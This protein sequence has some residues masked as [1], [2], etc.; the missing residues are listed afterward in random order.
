MPDLTA[1]ADHI[2]THLDV[3]CA[4]IGNRI[5]A[6][7]AERRAAEYCCEYLASLGLA[8]A[9]IEDFPF[10]LWGYDTCEVT[11]DTGGG[12]RGIEAIPIANSQ[13]TPE[14]GVE[15]ELIYVDNALPAD[16]AGADVQGKVL[17]IWGSYGE[18]TDKLEALNDCGAAG[19]LWVDE[20]LPFDW[21][22]SVGTPYDWR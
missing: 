18:S 4:D 10:H 6:S 21:P 2:Q 14:G 5:A 15:A 8:D 16:L 17:L 3:L 11:V 12:P 13:P 9:T 20:R 19:I 7:D 22:V 1:S